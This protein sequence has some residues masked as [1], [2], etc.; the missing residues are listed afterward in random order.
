[1]KFDRESVKFE[2]DLIFF[3]DDPGDSNCIV[4]RI[5][6]SF[7]IVTHCWI[8]FVSTFWYS[9][10]VRAYNEIFIIVEYW[11]YLSVEGLL[12]IFI[13]AQWETTFIGYVLREIL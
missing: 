5:E 8:G 3:E 2:N 4:S 10:E 6:V 7:E 12:L 11:A 1:M 13:L 9:E